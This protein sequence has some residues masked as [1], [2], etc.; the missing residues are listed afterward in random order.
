MIEAACENLPVLVHDSVAISSVLVSS[1]QLS[2][3]YPALAKIDAKKPRTSTFEVKCRITPLSKLPDL[4]KNLQKILEASLLAKNRDLFIRFW[5]DDLHK[6]TDGKPSKVEYHNYAMLIVKD[7]P[8]LGNGPDKKDCV[9]FH[10]KIQRFQL[11]IKTL[12]QNN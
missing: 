10:F 3:S 2:A 12:F 11:K 8:V 1:N 4:P 9:S 6:R 5:S 7:Y